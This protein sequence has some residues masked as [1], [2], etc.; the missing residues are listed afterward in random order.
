MK[1]LIVSLFLLAACGDERN[2]EGPK[3]KVVRQSFI[4]VRGKDGILR[5]ATFPVGGQN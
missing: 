3:E 4:D 2:G 5:Q 1:I